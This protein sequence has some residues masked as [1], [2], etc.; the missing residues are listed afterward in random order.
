MKKSVRMTI[1]EN[2]CPANH[3]CPSIR[4][5]SE[6]AIKQKYFLA[7]LPIIDQDKCIQC[8]KCIRFCPMGAIKAIEE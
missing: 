5:C 3:P 4:V 6:K 8:G 7:G 1:D 2:I